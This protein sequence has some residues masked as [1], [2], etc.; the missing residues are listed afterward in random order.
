MPG[1]V[2]QTWGFRLQPRELLRLAPLI[3]EDPRDVALGARV[4]FAVGGHDEGPTYRRFLRTPT[5]A[6]L[7]RSASDYPPLFRDYERL[8]ELPA[9]TLGREYVRQLDERGIHPV[10]L[11]RL[12]QAAYEG[13]SFS[14]EHAYVR[15]RVRDAH[16]LFHTLTGYGVDIF[17]EAGALAFTFGQTGN[18]GWAML[19]LL[20]GLTALT[21][22]RL[23][24]WLVAWRGYR[25]GRR[26]R[27]LPAVKDW[28]RLL[29]LPIERV[30]AEL[31]ISP[32][33]RYRPLELDEVFGRVAEE[34]G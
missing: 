9:G 18:K 14:S 1:S 12:T 23:D 2:R 24:G 5:G 4:F 25:R 34:T 17:G 10:E 3:R 11:A 33:H 6:Q 13:R 22:G 16:D 21:K 28:E 30:R 7:L 32:P 29:R 8:R 20:N 27:Y 26:A 19:V 15:D 31:G